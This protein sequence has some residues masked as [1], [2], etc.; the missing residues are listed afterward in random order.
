MVSRSPRGWLHSLM[1]SAR[2][3][4]SI[5]PRGLFA[6]LA[7]AFLIATMP[8]A[9]VGAQ[10]RPVY[11]QGAAGVLQQIEKLGTTASVLLVGAHPD[12]E[13]SA[14]IARSARGDHARTAYLSLNRG[15]GGQNAIGPELFDA[16]GVIRTEELLQARTLDGGEQFFTRA[17]DF[18]FSKTL[19]EA[20]RM[21]GE[22]E[23]LADAVRIIRTWRPLVVYSI[24][25]GTPADGH[26]HHQYSGVIT[27]EAF[28]AAADAAQFPEQ[29]AE[30]LRP[31]QALKLYRAAAFGQAGPEEG[32]GAT[33]LIET[34]QLD[35]LLAAATRK[36][37]PRAGTSTS[38]RRWAG[39]SCADP[40]S[41][42]ILVEAEVKT[43]E[44]EH[45]VFDGIDT[46]SR[47]SL[48]GGA[49]GRRAERAVVRPGSSR[50]RGGGR[51]QCPGA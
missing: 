28:R 20:R 25:S 13:D 21:W 30:G 1:I 51:F 22:K 5:I 11:S 15:E 35:P 40:R 41:G 38:P 36:S 2:C 14:F 45:G 39:P 46:T 12:D 23:V 19:A 4:R 10:V 8:A 33:A 16:L 17:F 43:S 26:G 48:P 7:A 42:L 27:P 49:S 9:R 37:P 44:Q 47:V 18:G 50:F 31:W 34:G 24:F 3:F 32:A 29:I 6:F